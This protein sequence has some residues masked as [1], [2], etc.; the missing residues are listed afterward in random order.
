MGAARLQWQVLKLHGCAPRY[1]TLLQRQV[2]K[3][4]TSALQSQDTKLHARM[5]ASALLQCQNIKLNA[6]VDALLQLQWQ[7][8]KLPN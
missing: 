1:T 6:R 4:H 2:F 5:R 8:L 3:L 7:V